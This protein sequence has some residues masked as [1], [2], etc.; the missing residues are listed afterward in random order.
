MKT[1]PEPITP[2]NRKSLSR[3]GIVGAVLGVVGI[4]LF[5]GF[6]VVLGQAGTAQAPRLFLSLCIPPALIGIG[7]LLYVL[8]SRRRA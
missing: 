7:M 8:V 3:A 6:W 4:L 1:P 2:F 5:L